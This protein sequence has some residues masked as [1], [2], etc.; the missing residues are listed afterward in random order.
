MHHSLFFLNWLLSLPLLLTLKMSQSL[1]EDFAQ[2]HTDSTRQRCN[3]SFW[4]S[5]ASLP[6]FFFP[7]LIYF[8]SV[9]IKGNWDGKEKHHVLVSCYRLASLTR[10]RHKQQP[11]L[12]APK[13]RA[14]K[15]S[16]ATCLFQHKPASQAFR[17]VLESQAE[18][19][20]GEAWVL[21]PWVLR[22]NCQR[23]LWIQEKQHSDS[24]GLC[25]SVIQQQ[26]RPRMP[27]RKPPSRQ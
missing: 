18:A 14:V 20:Q 19:S 1:L 11:D 13:F 23:G 7:P 2:S 26:E 12:G 3:P 9:L 21:P 5:K 25:S 22:G 24:G 16:E 6:L 27:R 4:L 15:A 17:T 10:E 8:I